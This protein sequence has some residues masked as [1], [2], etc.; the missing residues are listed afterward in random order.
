MTTQSDVY[1]AT[2]DNRYFGWGDAST[3]DINGVTHPI[4]WVED[5][6][7]GADSESTGTLKAV[8]K[9][10]LDGEDRYFGK[11]GYNQSHYG[12]EWD[13]HFFEAAPVEVTKTEYQ[14][15]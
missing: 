1:G 11:Y 9:V 2:H 4:E 10:T 5:S 15:I 7:T 6:N 8:F 13:G 3:I 14:E 12:S